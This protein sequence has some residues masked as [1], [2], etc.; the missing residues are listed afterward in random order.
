[1]V[2]LF[3]CFIFCWPRKN[4]IDWVSHK[5][6]IM[7]TSFPPRTF[8]LWIL[9]SLFSNTY[10]CVSHAHSINSMIFFFR[11]ACSMFI[12]LP[13]VFHTFYVIWYKLDHTTFILFKSPHRKS[14][15]FILILFL[16]DH[17]IKLHYHYKHYEKN[18]T[19]NKWGKYMCARSTCIAIYKEIRI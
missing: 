16:T 5:R 12:R 3:F 14:Y 2:Y 9:L 8:D 13:M 15:K 11:L 7:I 17:S 10:L 18:Q 4:T 6:N 19:K 1:M